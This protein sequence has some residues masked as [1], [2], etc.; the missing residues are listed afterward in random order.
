MNGY[1]KGAPMDGKL[2]VL[3][4]ILDKITEESGFYGSIISSEE[5]LIIINSNQMDPR[6][7]IESLAAQAASIF[8]EKSL[9]S[10]SDYP[11]NVTIDYPTRKIFIQRIYTADGINEKNRNG[12]LLIILM[13]NNMR[14]FRR[15]ANKL[16]NLAA[17]LAL[18]NL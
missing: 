1:V 6:I 16:K 9:L 3:Q 17:E 18:K 2:N 12:F 8:N 13:P 7:E 4:Q 5:G 14:Y 15:K 10:G 11:E